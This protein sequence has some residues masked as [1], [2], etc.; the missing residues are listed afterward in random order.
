MRL[1]GHAAAT[2]SDG[3]EGVAIV[4]DRDSVERAEKEAAVEDGAGRDYGARFALTSIGAKEVRERLN[5]APFLLRQIARGEL[6]EEKDDTFD[7]RPARLVVLK[8][9]PRLNPQAKKFIKE[10]NV[11]VHLW[12]GADGLPLRATIRQ[13][14]K[15]RAFLVITFESIDEDEYRYRIVDDRLVVVSHTRV[16]TGSGAGQRSNTKVESTLTLP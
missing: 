10:V 7:G 4:F 16:T 11:T 9:T 1:D 6:L 8:V 12:L 14:R 15:G 5:A 3:P 2:I 13:E